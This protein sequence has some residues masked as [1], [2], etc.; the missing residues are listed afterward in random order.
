MPLLG[1]HPKPKGTL[2][3]FDEDDGIEIWFKPLTQIKPNKVFSKCNIKDDEKPYITAE[4]E[5]HRTEQL[6]GDVVNVHAT[7]TQH[8]SVWVRDSNGL[9]KKLKFERKW[10]DGYMKIFE[11]NKYRPNKKYWWIQLITIVPVV[12]EVE[13]P[14][15]ETTNFPDVDPDK[16]K[17]IFDGDTSSLPEIINPEDLDTGFHK[18]DWDIPISGELTIQTGPIALDSKPDNKEQEEPVV[19]Q[20]EPEVDDV[21]SDN[22]SGVYGVTKSAVIPAVFSRD[23]DEDLSNGFWVKLK[24]GS[25]LR[26]QNDTYMTID[27]ITRLT[28]TISKSTVTGTLQQYN[29]IVGYKFRGQYYGF[30][31]P[32][33]LKIPEGSEIWIYTES[34]FNE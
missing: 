30:E 33:S 13:P 16:V 26:I 22:S 27:Q 8:Y 28:S 6:Y 14:D 17:D 18:F 4:Y 7:Y 11:K 20:S 19:K 21:P 15:Y 32:N 2:P 3:E 9:C 24:G 12:W 29:W 23:D 31:T 34:Y 25:E 5:Y 10:S 1:V